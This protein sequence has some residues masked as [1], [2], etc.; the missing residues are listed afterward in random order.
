MSPRSEAVYDFWLGMGT[1]LNVQPLAGGAPGGFNSPTKGM[2]IAFVNPLPCIL[3]SLHSYCCFTPVSTWEP[4]APDSSSFGQGSVIR[5]S[6][7]C[8][9]LFVA[10]CWHLVLGAG[11]LPNSVVA[12]QLSLLVSSLHT[13]HSNTLLL[14]GFSQ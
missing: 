11:P 14:C 5:A 8:S 4:I 10:Y 9:C 1:E 2:H 7:I 6:F 13:C 3:T 12:T